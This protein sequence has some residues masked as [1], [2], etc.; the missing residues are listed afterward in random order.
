MQDTIHIPEELQVLEDTAV[1]IYEKALTEK[2]AALFSA[3]LAM[4][5]IGLDELDRLVPGRSRI[6]HARK[7]IGILLWNTVAAPEKV[8]TGIIG[9]VALFDVHD[10]LRAG[11]EAIAGRFAA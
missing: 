8:D 5:K 10:A 6:R 7:N 9:K 2:Q 11:E 1:R 4:L 3:D